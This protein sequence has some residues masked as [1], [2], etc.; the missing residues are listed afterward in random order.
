MLPI[1]SS[2]YHQ[3]RPR[4]ARPHPRKRVNKHLTPLLPHTA[5]YKENDLLVRCRILRPKGCRLLRRKME[6][7]LLPSNAV[8]D[9]VYF[10]G[11]ALEGILHLPFHKA[12]ADNNP[13]SLGNELA[14]DMV[15]ITRHIVVDAVIAPKL[16]G[17]N[18]GHHGDF[19]GMFQ[20]YR[21]KIGQPIV[22]MEHDALFYGQLFRVFWGLARRR[23][24]KPLS[25][26]GVGSV[27]HRRIQLMNPMNKIFMPSRSI[28]RRYA[29][30]MHLLA[31]LFGRRPRKIACHNMHLNTGQPRQLPRKLLHM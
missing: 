26:K 29:M 8:I 31:N 4:K 30:D 1:A 19:E 9:D 3:L 15:N 28:I 11:G 17:M 24:R 22:R 20:L 12:G 5:S 7:E 13:P 16:R 23:R 6:L 21:R 27:A 25:A 10:I 14:L 2:G 18:R